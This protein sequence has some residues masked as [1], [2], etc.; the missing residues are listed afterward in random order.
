MSTL[1][2][3]VTRHWAASARSSWEGNRSEPHGIADGELPAGLV[4][5]PVQGHCHA[6]EDHAARGALE[7]PQ[8]EP[9]PHIRVRAGPPLPVHPA[10]GTQVQEGGVTQPHQTP[11]ALFRQEAVVEGGGPAGIP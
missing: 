7:V 2:I 11:P 3:N 4:G 6:E 9:D 8:P 5:L 10:Y 1:P